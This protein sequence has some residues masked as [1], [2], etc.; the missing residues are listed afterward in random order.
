MHTRYVSVT[1]TCTKAVQ[2][3]VKTVNVMAVRDTI[4]LHALGM[5]ELV[6][7]AGTARTD[8][9]FAQYARRWLLGPLPA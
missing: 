9:S 8:E 7:K 6:R 5:L 2:K 3:V 4:S 1:G